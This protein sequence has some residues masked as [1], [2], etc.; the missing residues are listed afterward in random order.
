M[1]FFHPS[2]LTF[3]FPGGNFDPP[4][5]LSCLPTFLPNTPSQTL[6][7]ASTLV[8][9]S[10]YI[11][12]ELAASQLR[13][14]VTSHLVCSSLSQV[15]HGFQHKGYTDGQGWGQHS[16]SCPVRSKYTWIGI[17][18]GRGKGGPEQPGNKT[19]LESPSSSSFFSPCHPLWL[20]L[21]IRPSVRWVGR[22]M[23]LEAKQAGIW[24]L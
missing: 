8:Q 12:G 16:S 20:V 9:P 2:T 10:I 1:Q 6:C 22:K 13:R 17:G 24:P 4:A 19:I 5:R 14:E 3:T 15:P 21:G 23:V 18:A 7:Q 11:L